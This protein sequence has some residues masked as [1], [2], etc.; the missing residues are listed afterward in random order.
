MELPDEIEDL[1]IKVKSI[2]NPICSAVDK[3]TKADKNFLFSAVRTDAGRS[4][5]PY[6][7]V[8]FLF[9]ELLGYKNLGTI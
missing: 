7:I 9:V 6:H 4:L 3:G 1:K 5:P 8:Y 2:L